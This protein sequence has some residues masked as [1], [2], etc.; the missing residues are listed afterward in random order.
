MH[1]H[2]DTHT[3]THTHTHTLSHVTVV[4]GGASP[5][6][7]GRFVS[8]GTFLILNLEMHALH[9]GYIFTVVYCGFH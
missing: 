9:L 8:D 2:T 5:F 6:E 3:H 4:L 1:T 7:F